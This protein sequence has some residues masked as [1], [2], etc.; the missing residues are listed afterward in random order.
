MSAVVAQ[1]SGASSPRKVAFASLIGTTIEWYDFF[2]YSTAAVLVFNQLFFPGFDP[3][4]GTLLAF[5]TFAAGFVARP[6]GAIVFGHFG[7]R[8][9]RKP[10]MVLTILIMGIATVAIGLL[11]TYGA[12]GVFA[13]VLLVVLRL[14]QGFALGGEWGGAVLMATEHSPK[15]RRGYFGSWPQAG[16]AVGLILAMTLYIPLESM[17]KDLFMAW[18]WRVPFLLSAVLVITGLVIRMKVAES[19]E[20]D[21]VK[22]DHGVVRLP[23]VEVLRTHPKQVFLVA[24]ASLA[25]GIFFYLIT[26]YNFVYAGKSGELDSTSMLV[27]V[28][29]TSAI[30]FVV[31]PLAGAL[32]DKFGG[33]RVYLWGLALIVIVAFPLYFALDGGTY[34]FIA[35]CYFAATVAVYIPWALTPAYFST[36]FDAKVRYS[37]LSLATTLGN[38]FGSAIAPLIAGALFAATNASISTSLYVFVAGAV[39][40]I[41]ALLLGRV[42]RNKAS[43]VRRGSDATGVDEVPAPTYSE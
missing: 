27:L 38:L 16:V 37:G 3:T 33:Q 32:S 23:V 28:I 34:G 13:P 9:G 5:S 19:P 31:T 6:I 25:P 15:G 11:P 29:V 26:V 24:G 21:R 30:G 2:I 22:A 17:S 14:T 4:T 43:Q 35:V 8:A 10:M 42:I 39:S 7:D 41:C 18:G 1:P 36:A 40:I 12:I 20:F